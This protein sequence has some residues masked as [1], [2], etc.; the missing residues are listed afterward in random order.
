MECTSVSAH[1]DAVDGDVDEA[2]EEADEAHHGEA[3]RGG[4]GDLDEFYYVTELVSIY[5]DVA[6]LG[7]TFSVG[8]VAAAHEA[9]RLDEEAVEGL[10]DASRGVHLS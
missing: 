4:C 7:R 2:D 8:L 1:E 6:I 10:G 9:D 5:W 3:D